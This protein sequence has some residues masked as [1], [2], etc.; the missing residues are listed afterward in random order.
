M[1]DGDRHGHIGQGGG[2]AAMQHAGAVHQAVA[3]LAA[4]GGAIHVRAVKFDAEQFIE[5]HRC[6]EI[7]KLAKAC[8]ARTR[9]WL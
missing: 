4:N 2:D 1:M 9:G 5:R 3:K 8:R 6:Q 7:A